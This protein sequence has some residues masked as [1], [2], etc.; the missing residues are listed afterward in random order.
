MT[1]AI[2]LRRFVLLGLTLLSACGAAD[3]GRSSAGGESG[4]ADVAVNGAMG[5][6]LSGRSALLSGDSDAATRIFLKGLAL[7]PDN[8]DLQ[9]GAFL[10]ALKAGRPEATE[11]ARQVQSGIAAQLLLANADIKAGRWSGAERRF[12]G[13][14]QKGPIQ[15]LL[16]VLIAWSQFG[17]GRADAALATLLPLTSNQRLSGLYGLHAALMADLAGRAPL[18]GQMYALAANN[19]G[20]ANIGLARILASWSARNGQIAEARK[21]FAPFD[22]NGGNL[23]LA[24][25]N[26]IRHAADIQVRDAKD[27][28][29]EA[30]F[31][32]AA[33]S[34]GQDGNNLSDLLLRMALDL[35]PDMGL[36]RLLQAD[37][38]D[39][40]G[41]PADALDA[42]ADA[43]SDDPFYQSVEMRRAAYQAKLGKI[44]PAL[45]I[46]DRLQKEFP[47]RQEPYILRADILRDAKRFAE[48]VTAYSGAID[49]LGRTSATDW[50]LFYERGIAYDQSKQP[51]LA[52]KDFLHALQLAPDQPFVLNYLGYSWTEQGRNLDRAHQMIERAVALRPDDGAI[53]DSLGW[54][55]L[56]RGNTRGAVRLLQ[57]AV[58][59]QPA[60]P[61]LNAHLGDAYWAAGRKL[62]AQFQWRRALVSSPDPDEVPKLQAKLRDSEA[63]LGNPPAKPAAP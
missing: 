48:A 15:I 14:V 61:T 12:D 25:P 53:V 52:E 38:L 46:L 7:E 1:V 24:V 43:D 54:V 11:L 58:E 45:A 41:H 18:A 34:R 31:T 40:A 57:R 3:A 49:R 19:S 32:L 37:A 2:A 42:L 55:E 5:A 60:D 47:D 63:A 62:E 56:K 22:S 28:L 51:D 36:A 16:P 30:Y 4:S 9:N 8:S 13:I 23:A 33:A 27:G 17:D 10:A 50:P 21:R 20:G 35:R 59:L 44:D 29:A 26:L 39:E 6:Y